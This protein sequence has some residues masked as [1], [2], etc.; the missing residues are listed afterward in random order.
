MKVS[1]FFCGTETHCPAL[2]CWL[3]PELCGSLWQLPVLS[4]HCSPIMYSCPVLLAVCDSLRCG[5]LIV[6]LPRW[7]KFPHQILKWLVL[8]GAAFY[9]PAQRS[10]CDV[11]LCCVHV[12]P[13][14]PHTV[15]VVHQWPHCNVDEKSCFSFALGALGFCLWC[16]SCLTESLVLD[17]RIHAEWA[18]LKISPM[19]TVLP[20]KATPGRFAV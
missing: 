15:L 7:V 3:R 5:S 20:N 10:V 17:V 6:S 18:I 8:F 16:C 4:L 19:E 13:K 11:T 9:C 1:C 12:S 2:V 14:S